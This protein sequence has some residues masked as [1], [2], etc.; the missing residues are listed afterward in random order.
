VSQHLQQRKGGDMD[1]F[2]VIDQIRRV[3]HHNTVRSW[4]Q[5]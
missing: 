2:R 4:S 5:S 3:L 1:G